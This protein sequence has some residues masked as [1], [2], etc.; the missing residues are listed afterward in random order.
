M[1]S[2]TTYKKRASIYLLSILGVMAFIVACYLVMQAMEN[3][4][5]RLSMLGLPFLAVGALA[6]DGLLIAA[7]FGLPGLVLTFL[8]DSLLSLV[9]ID[10]GAIPPTIAGALIGLGIGIHLMRNYDEMS[11][12]VTQPTVWAEQKKFAEALNRWEFSNTE[13]RFTA[14]EGDCRR[15]GPQWRLA[16][17]R[18]TLILADR[19]KVPEFAAFWIAPNKGTDLN[20]GTMSFGRKHQTELF[21]FCVEGR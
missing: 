3:V 9:G 17:R 6:R 13:R 4:G 5:G 21:Y 8:I 12:F 14:A 16:T 10:S 11:K 1:E 15:K 18:E 2:A 20:G 19:T 7:C